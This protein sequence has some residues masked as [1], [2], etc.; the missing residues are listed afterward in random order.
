MLRLLW[1]V[2]LSGGER[3]W[4]AARI[5]RRGLVVQFAVQLAVG[6][7]SVVGVRSR[8]LGREGANEPGR[9]C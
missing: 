5:L 8:S 9:G 2:S 1:P 3:S 7:M 4:G 6:A